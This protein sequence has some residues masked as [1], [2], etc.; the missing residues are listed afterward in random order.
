MAEHRHNLNYFG[1]THV[2]QTEKSKVEEDAKF[3]TQM[4]PGIKGTWIKKENLPTS[5]RT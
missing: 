4:A 3:A 1:T 5:A 2:Q